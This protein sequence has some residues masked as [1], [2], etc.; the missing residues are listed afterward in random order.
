MLDGEIINTLFGA[1]GG[2]GG[3]SSSTF[4][5]SSGQVLQ[6]NVAAR[7][8]NGTNGTSVGGVNTAGLGG[9]GGAGGAAGGAAG[10]LMEDLLETRAEVRVAR[11][12]FLAVVVVAKRGRW[13]SWWWRR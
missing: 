7:G 9:A 3:F 6:P 13:W 1:V 5:V 8:G 2:L 11:V 12:S 10:G 4:S